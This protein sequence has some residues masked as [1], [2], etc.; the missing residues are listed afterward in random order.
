[1]MDRRTVRNMESFM[2]NILVKLVHLVA[3]IIKTDVLIS[4]DNTYYDILAY[5]LYFESK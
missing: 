4:G 1:M 3:F 2:T 5:S